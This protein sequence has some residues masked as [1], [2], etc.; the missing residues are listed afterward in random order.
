MED[1]IVKEFLEERN[2]LTG[3]KLP[4][5]ELLL[6]AFEYACLCVMNGAEPDSPEFT[7]Y[8]VGKRMILE[9]M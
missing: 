9:R 2:R 7:M 8:A 5:A 6:N 1:Q 4:E 3:G